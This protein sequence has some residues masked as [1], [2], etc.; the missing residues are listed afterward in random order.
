MTGDK[1]LV[2]LPLLALV[3]AGLSIAGLWYWWTSTADQDE[4]GGDASSS[5]PP[6]E[7]VANKE[8][9]DE[10]SGSFFERL[11]D[12]LSPVSDMVKKALPQ[13]QPT[14]FDSQPSSRVPSAFSAPSMAGSHSVE[15]MRL[16]RDL[17]DGSL[18][19][20]IDGRRYHS[21]REISDP[22]MGRH[23]MGNAQALARFARLD[24]Y[25][26]PEDEAEAFVPPAPSPQ[27]PWQEPAAPLPASL[28]PRSV[29]SAAEGD[30]AP[31][32]ALSMAEEIEELLQFRLT[33]TPGMAHRSIH[34]RQGAGGGIRIEV[35]GQHYDGVGD[36]PDAEV[37]EFIQATTREWE[38]RQ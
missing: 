27:P 6:V 38:A 4:T 36:V 26:V 33:M 22:Q 14:S 17:S 35:D 15:V 25:S 2:I 23:F 21:L 20:E 29:T 13:S 12:S 9:D 34:I 24:A 28:S 1:L 31:A 16:L 18:I 7:P 30:A 32:G 10:F 11:K 37:R 3:L 8:Q 19:V 5:P